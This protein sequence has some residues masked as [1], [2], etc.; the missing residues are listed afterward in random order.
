[1]NEELT[2]LFEADQAD[3]RNT[4]GALQL[5][6]DGDVDKRDLERR[7]QVNRLRQEGKLVH[8]QDY[9]HASLIL[10]HGTTSDD[11]KQANE[12]AKKA[13]EL[14]DDSARWLYAATLDRYL[15]S[16]GQP[17]KYGTQFRLNEE[18]IPELMPVSSE[19]TDEER[20][21]W[22]VPPLAEAVNTFKKKY[23]M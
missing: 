10:Q 13:V 14:G 2:G 4:Q 6:P 12:L 15:V 11:Y 18:K 16:L 20:A 8:S 19:T 17:Q 22:H 9:H 1:M 3:R 21:E 7:D 23:R 5:K